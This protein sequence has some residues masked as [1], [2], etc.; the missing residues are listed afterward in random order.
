MFCQHIFKIG[1][2]FFVSADFNGTAGI[3]WSWDRQFKVGRNIYIWFILSKLCFCGAFLHAFLCAH[4]FESTLLLFFRIQLSKLIRHDMAW[5]SLSMWDCAKIRNFLFWHKRCC[6]CT[7]F[8]LLFV[9]TTFFKHCQTTSQTAVWY[10]CYHSWLMILL[11]YMSKYVKDNILSFRYSYDVLK[12]NT[13]IFLIKFLCSLFSVG[14]FFSKISFHNCIR[15]LF[16]NLLQTQVP[17][18]FHFFVPLAAYF[19]NMSV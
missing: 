18:N 11:W 4:C 14:L 10:G 3:L 19:I 6:K 8:C 13:L 7:K 9:Y 16:H 17:P 2:L 15:S 5:T 12:A 1:L